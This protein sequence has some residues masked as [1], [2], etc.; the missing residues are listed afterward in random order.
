MQSEVTL[1]EC[2]LHE[3]LGRTQTRINFFSGGV[4]RWTFKTR[5]KV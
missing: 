4:A 2:V 5:A 1:T 3:E